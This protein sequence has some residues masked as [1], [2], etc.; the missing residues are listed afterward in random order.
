MARVA[1]LNLS[2]AVS[3]RDALFFC[4][5][6]KRKTIRRESKHQGSHSGVTLYY[7]GKSCGCSTAHISN[8]KK[9]LQYIIS[10]PLQT[11]F[12]N[13]SPTAVRSPQVIYYT[14]TDCTLFFLLFLKTC[15]PV[16][17]HIHQMP[18]RSVRPGLLV[19]YID[20]RY[21]CLLVAPCVFHTTRIQYFASVLLTDTCA[22][23][24]LPPV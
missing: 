5:L 21:H 6:W 10:Q 2:L 14:T 7:R 16:S 8:P 17:L 4:S 20:K 23:L 11:F 19:F 12:T 1:L 24:T 9:R 13:R 3:E 18:R 15:V 22:L